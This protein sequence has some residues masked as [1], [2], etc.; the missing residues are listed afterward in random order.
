MI[1]LEEIRS[2]KAGI[3]RLAE[4]IALPCGIED[5]EGRAAAVLLVAMASLDTADKATL[6]AYTGLPFEFVKEKLG[7][8]RANLMLRGDEIE[9]QDWFDGQA[10]V[11]AFLMEVMTLTGELRRV[12]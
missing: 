10:G 7:V 12:R 9:F 3:L 5:E 11:I 1:D 6:V 4:E 8:M 2:R